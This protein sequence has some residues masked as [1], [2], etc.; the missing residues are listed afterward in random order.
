VIPC[1]MI[2]VARVS[3]TPPL[4]IG[5]GDRRPNKSGVR[6]RSSVGIIRFSQTPS[7]LAHRLFGAVVPF[8]YEQRKSVSYH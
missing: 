6:W 8:L 2:S 1:F 5:E 4:F 3:T 7:P